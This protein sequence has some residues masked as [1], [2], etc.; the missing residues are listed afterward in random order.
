MNE[1]FVQYLITDPSY[2]GSEVNEFESKLIQVLQ[3]HHV[4]TACFRD[5]FSSNYEE[6]A[7]VFVKICTKF[8]VQNILIN[9]NFELAK[10][11][12][13]GIHFTSKQLHLIQEAKNCDMYVIASCHNIKE[14]EK[15]QQ[16]YVNA[17]TY[18]PI[19]ETPNK[20]EPKGLSHLKKILSLYDMNIIALGGIITQEQINELK[21]TKA[22]GFAS[23]RYFISS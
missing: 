1:E 6:L 2:Y 12:K 15:A 8:K 10:K 21:K 14:I 22:Y 11:L 19:F 18:S 20:G 7:N 3:N 13:C 5:K 4:Q 17:I 16:S 23:I 9:E